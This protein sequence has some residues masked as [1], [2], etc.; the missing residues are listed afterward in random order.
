MTDRERFDA[1]MGY[2]RFDRACVYYFG[3]WEETRQRWLAEGL[4]PDRPLAEQV[5]MDP[6]WEQGMWDAHGLMTYGPIHRGIASTM[7]EGDTYRVVRHA[8]GAITRESKIGASIP[9][10]L[11]EALEPTRQ[12]WELF[13]K[14]LD[15]TSPERQLDGQK[16]AAKAR[17]LNGRPGTVCCFGGSLYGWPREW[18]GVEALSMLSYDD[19]A[20]YEEIIDFLTEYFIALNRPI[21]EQTQFEFAYIFEDCCGKSGPLFSP[22]TYRHYYHKHYARLVAF[23][24]SHGVKYVLLDSDGD[25]ELLIPCWLDSGIDIIFPIEVGTW[26][27]DPVRLRQ[28]YGRQLRMLGGVDKHL[29][30]GDPLLLRTA[31]ERLKPVVDEGGYIPLPDHRIPPDCSLDQFKAYVAMFKSVFNTGANA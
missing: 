31:L 22:A 17:E 7:E 1:M 11:K 27:G 2:A 10:H 24:K 23:Y 30:T 20:L 21:L 28:K 19:P 9:Q 16:L 25:A 5:G 26:H 29:I 3:Q 18:L 6:E 12:S 14:S 8:S 13:R 4:S 15:Q